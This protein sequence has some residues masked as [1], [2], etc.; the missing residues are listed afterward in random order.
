[1]YL[2]RQ[3]L[4]LFLVGADNYINLLITI[5]YFYLLVKLTESN[6]VLALF[7]PQFEQVMLSAL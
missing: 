7:S 6:N 1:M 5:V 4:A 3:A 2:L